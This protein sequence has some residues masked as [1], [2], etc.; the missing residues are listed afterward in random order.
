MGV[1]SLLLL[2]TGMIGHRPDGGYYAVCFAPREG[3]K[4]RF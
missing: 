1:P 4:L 2:A 3:A